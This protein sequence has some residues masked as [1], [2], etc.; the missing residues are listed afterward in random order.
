MAKQSRG[1]KVASFLDSA[2]PK[3]L[4][5]AGILGVG[6]ILGFSFYRKH[7]EKV[8]EEKDRTE[9]EA[10]FQS[11]KGDTGVAEAIQMATVL[12]QA[13]YE[14][15]VFSPVFNWFQWGDG[16]DEDSIYA[17]AAQIGQRKNWD[18][19]VMAYSKLYRGRSLLRDLQSDLSADDYRKVMDL[20]KSGTGGS[21]NTGG[22]NSGGGHTHTTGKTTTYNTQPKPTTSTEFTD[23][24]KKLYAGLY[25]NIGGGIDIGANF[26]VLMDYAYALANKN[27]WESIKTAYATVYRG[28]NLSADLKTRLE[29]RK[30]LGSNQ[31]NYFFNALNG[32]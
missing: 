4:L 25:P 13:M 28:R 10:E 8:R 2:T 1:R 32:R 15:F 26:N 18:K 27:K 19:V 9:F 29:P 12:Y 17:I 23:W 7:R 5:A 11:G 21:T 3:R 22:G 30:R 14:N 6:G 20:I 24:A 16:T 31:Y